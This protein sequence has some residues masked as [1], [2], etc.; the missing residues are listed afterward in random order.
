V[1]LREAG[2]GEQ[3]FA[4]FAH[5]LLHLGQLPAEH[6]GDGLELL[7]DVFGVELSEHGADRGGDHLGVL[8][9]HLGE[10]VQHEWDP[11]PLP[12][13]TQHD[14]PDRLFQAGVGVGDDQLHPTQ[15]AGLQA[16]EER[17]PEGAVL[18]VADVE[19]EDL[20]AAVAGHPGRDHHRLRHHPMVHPGLAV[21]GVQEHVR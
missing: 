2:E 19:A 14:R 6:A 10:D 13:R 17:G 5:H 8:A 1:R 9:R 3:V 18:G 21:G 12:G 4:G 15:P 7:G 16:A 11:A 20:P